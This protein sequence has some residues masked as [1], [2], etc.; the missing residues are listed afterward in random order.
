MGLSGGLQSVDSADE[1]KSSGSSLS[2]D[3]KKV[4][5]W[6]KIS[7]EEPTIPLSGE[8]RYLTPLWVSR[9]EEPQEEPYQSDSAQLITT[10]FELIRAAKFRSYRLEIKYKI[11]AALK[12]LTL[13]EQHVLIQFWSPR[14]V[15]KHQLLT[16]DDQPFGLGVAIEELC[17]Y[18][19]VSEQNAF[20]VDKDHE[21]DDVSPPARVFRQG[22]PEWT[23]DITNYKPEDFPQQEYAIL[24]NLY[25]YLALPV[26]DSTTGLCVGVLELLTSSN[27]MSYDFEVQ[28][29]HEA[30]KM[31]NLTSPQAFGRPPSKIPNENKDGELDKVFDILKVVCDIHSLPLAQTW[32]LSP[33]CSFVSHEKVI[34]KSCSSFDARCIGKVCMSTADLP[35][36]VRDLGMWHFRKACREQ[37]L[38]KS[39]GFVGRALLAHGSCYCQDITELT[40]EEYPLVHKARMSGLTGCF[41]IFLHSVDDDYV[42]EFFL[43]SDS[44]NGIHVLNLVQTL[45]QR[46]EVAF[47]FELG[48]LS[49]IEVIGPPRDVSYLSSSI[50]P[51]TI[52]ISSTTMANTSSY[53][54]GSSDSKSFLASIAKTNSL[55]V[56]SQMS[57]KQHLPNEQGGIITVTENLVRNDVIAN[58]INVKIK[59]TAT[60]Y[61]DMSMQVMNDISTNAGKGNNTLKQGKKT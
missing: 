58:D 55:D 10:G 7:L 47:G 15:G 31:K 32:A 36:H 29:V 30:L 38:D 16:T 42:L 57:S 28:Q 21:E 52:Q 24:C 1:N 4:L 23:F 50:K 3:Q 5:T 61:A 53:G 13:R 12:L 39:C 49:L 51:H 18:R 60:S 35:F 19:K 37:H 46:V 41:T 11:R 17:F 14:I 8:S 48:E 25:G 34:K 22:L 2:Q 6:N 44:K 43:L 27:Y 33:S 45:K 9:Y 56:A 40:E 54:M 59:D 26:F 20:L